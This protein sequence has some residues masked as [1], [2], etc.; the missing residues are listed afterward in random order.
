MTGVARRWGPAALVESL[1]L[2]GVLLPA[3]NLPDGP[4][5]LSVLFHLG[6]HALLAFTLVRPGGLRRAAG[7]LSIV[8][9]LGLL[10]EVLQATVTTSRSADPRDAVA[11][12]VGG[13]VGWFVASRWPDLSARSDAVAGRLRR[14]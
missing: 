3:S 12:L 11:D 14:R 5:V 8:L 10:S 7:V 1:I 13:A 2:V 9:V 6:A 4:E